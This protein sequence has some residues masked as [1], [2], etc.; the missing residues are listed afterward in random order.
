M[1]S[2]LA[3][4]SGIFCVAFRLVECGRSALRRTTACGRALILKDFHQDGDEP[5]GAGVLVAELMSG[6]RMKEIGAV[7]ERHAV[8]QEETFGGRHGVRNMGADFRESTLISSIVPVPAQ[9]VMTETADRLGNGAEEERG[10]DEKT[11]V[12]L[13]GW[14]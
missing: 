11:T 7:G 9:A 5:D 4:S 14:R 13:S 8:E 1:S 10:D 3:R 12:R 6:R 2:W